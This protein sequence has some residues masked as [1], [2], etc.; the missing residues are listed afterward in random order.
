MR[1][2]RLFSPTALTTCVCAI[3]KKPS[4][5]TSTRS[6]QFSPSGI[7]SHSAGDV[8]GLDVGFGVGGLDGE[9][10]GSKVG[11]SDGD[12]VGCWL[13]GGGVLRF[14]GDEVGLG[15][16]GFMVGCSVGIAVV[17][18][19]VWMSDSVGISV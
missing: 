11:V 15:V 4:H 18:L 14:F 10:V 2:A 7:K 16:V 13:V 19:R 5:A 3:S 8:V 6:S 1:G 17:G 12:I 9:S